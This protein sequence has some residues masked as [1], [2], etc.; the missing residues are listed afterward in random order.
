M[1]DPDT[2]LDWRRARDN[3]GELAAMML[4]LVDRSPDRL[5][6]LEVPHELVRTDA[7][8][9]ANEAIVRREFDRAKAERPGLVVAI[10]PGNEDF[11]NAA[12]LV[13]VHEHEWVGGRCAN[14][15]PDTREAA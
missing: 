4:R 14:G 15:C 3:H 12:L 2:F 5:A 6:I 8:A 9:D 7:E 10:K 1:T 13:A 11:P